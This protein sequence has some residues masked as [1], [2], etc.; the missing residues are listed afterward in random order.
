[1]QQ[2]A[3][4]ANRWFL[5]FYLSHQKEC[6]YF[7]FQRERERE[8]F[9]SRKTLKEKTPNKTEQKSS[10]PSSLRRADL[11]LACLKSRSYFKSFSPQTLRENQVPTLFT[12]R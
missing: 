6:K 11:G 2:N 7:L 4:A 3:Y 1:M 9:Y 12:E 8:I 10:L 5:N